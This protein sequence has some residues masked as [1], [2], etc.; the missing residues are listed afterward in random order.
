MPGNV[1]VLLVIQDKKDKP[2]QK[3]YPALEERDVPVR[4][5]GCVCWTGRLGIPASCLRTHAVGPSAH[6]CAGR[7]LMLLKRDI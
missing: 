6:A 5:Q 4:Y 3:G 1:K 7:G 2:S